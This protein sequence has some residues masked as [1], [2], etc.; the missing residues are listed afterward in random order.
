[1]GSHIL[2]AKCRRDCKKHEL[3]ADRPHGLRPS[4]AD[5]L[6]TKVRENSHAEGSPRTAPSPRRAGSPPCAARSSRQCWSPSHLPMSKACAAGSFQSDVMHYVASRAALAV[7]AVRQGPEFVSRALLKWIVIQGIETALIDPGKPWQNGST[8]SFNGKFRN[9]CLRH[10]G[11][12][13]PT[14]CNSLKCFM[15]RLPVVDRFVT[16][17]R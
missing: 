5:T 1:M 16:R 17:D 9:E 15:I 12:S 10:Y 14:G 3:N 11:A 6:T 7:S 4:A 2:C 8:E 13:T